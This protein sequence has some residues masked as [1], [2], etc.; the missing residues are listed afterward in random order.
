MVT[1]THLALHPL[2]WFSNRSLVQEIEDVENEDSTLEGYLDSMYEKRGST[3][4][5]G[6][7]GIINSLMSNVQLDFF[8]KVMK[9]CWINL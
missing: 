5:S 3:R 6:L 8:R 9:F 1:M 7:K 4:E 2:V